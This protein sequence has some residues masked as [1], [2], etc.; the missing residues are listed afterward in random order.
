MSRALQIVTMSCCAVGRHYRNAV[1]QGHCNIIV[2]GGMHSCD[3]IVGNSC[4]PSLSQL[5]TPIVVVI[6]S[7]RCFCKVLLQC[8]VT[9]I[10]LD[11]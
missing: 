11:Y 7:T 6:V 2:I 10:A 8:A 1:P 4:G 3:L 5:V 9:A